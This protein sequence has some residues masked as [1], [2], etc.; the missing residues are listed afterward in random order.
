MR[1]DY[2]KKHIIWSSDKQ[3]ASNINYKYMSSDRF[4]SQKVI[5]LES[6]KKNGAP[7]QTPVWLVEDA[8]TIYVRTDAKTWKAKRIRKNPAVRIAPSNMR[9]AILGSWVKGEAHFVEGEE[10]NHIL[11]LFKKKYGIIGRIIDFFNR[12][13]GK[14]SSTVIAIKV[15]N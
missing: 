8:G 15:E 7:V 2:W 6:Y 11:N 9:G 10:A 13:R 12:L 1:N 4:S 5:S 3:L 14:R